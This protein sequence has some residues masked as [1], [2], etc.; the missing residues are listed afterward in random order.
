L[1]VLVGVDDTPHAQAAAR[2]GHALCAVA[3]ELHLIAVVDAAKAARAT[4]ASA[5]IVD[6]MLDTARA[7]LASAASVTR[8]TSQGLYQGAPA[9][10]LLERSRRSGATLIAVGARPH[11]RG[12]SAPLGMVA[13][14]IL[15]DAT[16]S[17]LLSRPARW[18]ADGPQHILVGIDGSPQATQ[19]ATVARA[20]GARFG[21]HVT[22]LVG[23]GGKPCDAEA[24]LD[25]TPD[26]AIDP[27]PPVD[28]LVTASRGADLLIVG[29]RGLHGLDTLGS[30]STR[31]AA[32]A[33]CP[34]LVIRAHRTTGNAAPGANADRQQ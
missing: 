16:C 3:G 34:V 22:A 12:T 32:R 25:I 1:C 4:V 19:A 31:V 17:V 14:T 28:A 30:V 6:Q 27:K 23:L 8:P 24:V 10:V 9:T 20:L 21:A 33:H 11:S 5:A 15:R 26:A 2:Q 18:S 29:N 7:A 13:S